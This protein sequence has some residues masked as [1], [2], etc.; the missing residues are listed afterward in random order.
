MAETSLKTTTGSGTQ[1]ATQSPQTAGQPTA[2]GTPSSG[3][4]PGTAS[5]LLNSQASTGVPLHNTTLPTANLNAT[6]TTQVATP[7]PARHLHPALFG[8]SAL[9]FLIAIWLFWATSRS[10]KTTT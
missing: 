9:L 6:P 3:V 8:V 7:P 10:A 5:N 4:Q 2:T 1:A